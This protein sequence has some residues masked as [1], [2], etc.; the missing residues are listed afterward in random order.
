MNGSERKVSWCTSLRRWIKRS[1]AA[2]LWHTR[3]MPLMGAMANRCQLA[4]TV[5]GGPAFPFLKRRRTGTVQILIYHRVNNEC[6]PFFPATPLDV[7]AR[8]MEYLAATHYICSLDEAVRRLKRGDVPPNAAVVT[9]DDGYRD[10]FVHAFP[11]LTRLSIPATIFLATHAIGTGKTL[12]HD[13]VFS[14]FR[15]TREPVLSG[16]HP[17]WS[18]CPVSTPREKLDAQRRVLGV[19]RAMDD[20]TRDEWVDRLADRL[21]VECRYE[22]PRL[23]LTWHDVRAMHPHGIAFGAHTA[24]HAILSRLSDGKIAQEILESTRSIE[25][26]LGAAPT[27]FAYPNGGRDDFNESCK[28]ALRQAGYECA[29]TTI[30]GVN[31]PGQDLYELR[32]GQPWDEHLPTFA[33]KQ[34][35]YR[36]AS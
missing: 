6:D 31:E 26:N 4:K 29:V 13:R 30:H 10:N 33:A 35:W 8:Q 25:K 16:F 22:D 3:T 12:W 21:K 28:L 2:I 11:I 27:S 23:M 36:L 9:F 1:A 5:S 18:P 24:S 15:E 14:A 19:L 32:R 7:F 34:M 20:A 17:D